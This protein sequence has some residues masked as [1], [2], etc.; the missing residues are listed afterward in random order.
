MKRSVHGSAWHH[1]VPV[2]TWHNPVPVAK[3]HHPVPVAAWLASDRGISADDAV[4]AKNQSPA[5]RLLQVGVDRGVTALTTTPVSWHQTVPVATWHYPVP[6]AKWRNPIPVAAWLASDSGISADDAVA[7]KNQSPA[8]R[9]LQVGVGRGVTALTTIPVSW[10][11]T[12][13]VATW[14]N[15]VPVATWHNPIPVAAWLASDSGIAADDAVAAKNQ[16]PAAGFSPR[17]TA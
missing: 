7:A 4:A 15:I 14:H 12:V 16:S 8:S 13:P 11:H 3:W 10:H 2:A 1:I 5:S 6:V 17:D 9:L